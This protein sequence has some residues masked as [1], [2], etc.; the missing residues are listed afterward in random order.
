MPNLRTNLAYLCL[1]PCVGLV[2]TACSDDPQG[3]RVS[4]QT[5]A[6]T[7]TEN[8]ES[9]L[10]S[11]S[12]A[13]RFLNDSST[14]LSILSMM[15]DS[16][17][18]SSTQSACDPALDPGLC[19]PA[20]THCE[21][22]E[23][24]KQDLSEAHAELDDGIAELVAQLREQVFTQ[25]NLEEESETSVT[26][27]LGPSVLCGESDG[28]ADAPS[29]GGEPSLEIEEEDLDCAR[30]A[31]K[32]QLRLRVTSPSEGDVDVAVLLTEQRFNPMNLSIHQD[33]LAISTDLGELRKSVDAL[34]EDL[35]GLSNMSGVL[36]VE[37]LKNGPKDVSLRLNV[38]EDLVVE[39]ETEDGALSLRLGKSVPTMELRMDGAAEAMNATYDY[40][41]FTMKA[42]LATLAG[43][44]EGAVLVE[45]AP[46]LPGVDAQEPSPEP[47]APVQPEDPVYTGDV[48][49]FVAGLEGSARFDG[50]SDSLKLTGLGLGDATSTF[51]HEGKKL[52]TLDLN[53]DSGRHFDLSLK[54]DDTEATATVS[55]GFDLVLGF[56]FESVADQLDVAD[57]MLM[58]TVRVLLSGSSPSVRFRDGGLEVVSGQLQLTS[59]S[60]PDANIS[61]QS[62][63]CLVDIDAESEAPGAHPLQ[64]LA[65]AMCE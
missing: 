60:L 17:T 59:E 65:P 50:D 35:N 24:T 36:E 8:T 46:A 53:K 19:P 5:A 57:F 2:L 22:V 47:S 32:N 30:Q 64:T 1:G 29:L 61:V 3:L 48:E 52:F 26:Y 41:A 14:M 27:L 39:G 33:R 54:G 15:A 25:Q 63:M 37:L 34:G 58:D 31:E 49:L 23:P 56:A 40:G 45:P 12:D 28:S 18:C 21:E 11:M 38:H 6:L 62:G 44:L 7:A 10:R 55:P 13:M 43:D 4:H 9:A 16:G 20:E 51:S 42:P